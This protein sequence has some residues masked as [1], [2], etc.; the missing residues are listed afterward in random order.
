MLMMVICV[1]SPLVQHRSSRADTLACVMVLASASKFMLV[2]LQEGAARV[3]CNSPRCNNLSICIILY[4]LGHLGR[5]A[6]ECTG[7]A[8]LQSVPCI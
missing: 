8:G 4:P 2:P 1:R 6:E 3:A 7:M 5:V